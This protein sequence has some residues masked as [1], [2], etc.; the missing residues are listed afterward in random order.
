MRVCKILCYTKHRWGQGL[1][2]EISERQG[3]DGDTRDA[4][5]EKQARLKDPY[6]HCTGLFGSSSWKLEDNDNLDFKTQHENF[7][8]T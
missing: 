8:P 2:R 3:W 6:D 7:F 5:K 1:P 4:K